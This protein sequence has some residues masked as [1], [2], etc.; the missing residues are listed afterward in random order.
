M[1]G[2][3]NCHA[4]ITFN[5]GVEWIVRFR[6]EQ[7]ISPPP[8]MRDYILRSEAA[9]LLFLQTHCSGIPSPKIYD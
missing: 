3:Q 9:T 2:G 5:D 7:V 4:I 6:L 1:M 8:E